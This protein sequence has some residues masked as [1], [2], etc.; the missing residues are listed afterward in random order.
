MVARW[1][2]YI[3]GTFGTGSGVISIPSGTYSLPTEIIFYGIASSN[4]GVPGAY[5]YPSLTLEDGVIFNVAPNN[6]T[7]TNLIALSVLNTSSPVITVDG[8]GESL[9]ANAYFNNVSDVS[10]S[11]GQ[12]LISVVD[13]IFYYV[14]ATGNTLFSSG[15]IFETDSGSEIFIGLSNSFISAGTISSAG[16]YAIN[17]DESS[18]VDSSYAPSTSYIALQSNINNVTV[19]TTVSTIVDVVPPTVNYRADTSEGTVAYQFPNVATVPFNGWGFWVWIM[20]SS[21][22]NP[23]TFT[24]NGSASERLMNPDTGVYQGTPWSSATSGSVQGRRIW[25]E[26]SSTEN[27]WLTNGQNP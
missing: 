25:V 15:V 5:T 22:T 27:A 2:I 20:V 16:S 18:H 19:D 23:I 21:G 6:I 3:D 24:V 10:S 1:T 12:P 13:N 11:G 4:V 17:A 26:W 7:F 8:L 9:S 14:S